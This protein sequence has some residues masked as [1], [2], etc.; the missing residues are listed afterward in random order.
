[1]S[2]FISNALAEETSISSAQPSGGM[3]SII[4]MVLIVIVFYFMIIRPQ[5]KRNKEHRNLMNSISKGDEV[6]TSGGL[7]GRITK[8]SETG[9]LVIALNENNEVT[10]K[11]DFVVAVLPKGTMKSL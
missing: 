2:F 6:L 4:M 7:I 11:R 10:I 5:Q 3:A 8:V 9:Y 1:M